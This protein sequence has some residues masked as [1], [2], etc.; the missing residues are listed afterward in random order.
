MSHSIPAEL[1]F[2]PV[3]RLAISESLVIDKHWLVQTA[4]FVKVAKRVIW[5]WV[6]LKLAKRENYLAE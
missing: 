6:Q 5:I 3:V 1:T 2:Y 4:A